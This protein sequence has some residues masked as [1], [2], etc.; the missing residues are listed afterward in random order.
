M[1]E[2]RRGPALPLLLLLL[3][4]GCAAWF[5]GEAPELAA[6]RAQASELRG[7]AFTRRVPL[8]WITRGKLPELVREELADAVRE[9]YATRYRDAAAALGLIPPDLDLVELQIRLNQEQIAG[10]YSVKKRRMYVLVDGPQLD[11]A[12][13]IH[14]LVHALQH[15]HFR[16]TLEL[17]QALRRND[18]VVLALGAAAEGDAMLVMQL[19]RSGDGELGAEGA[20]LQRTWLRH[21]LETPSG[22][23]AE[24]PR[25]VRLGLLFP[26][27]AGFDLA[28]QVY[29][30]EGRA[31]LD[32]LL[33]DAPLSSL[34]VRRPQSRHDVEFLRLPSARAEEL[35]GPGCRAGHDNVAGV[36]ALGALFADHGGAPA[37]APL[38]GSWS[39]DRF[40]RLDCP[41]GPE[42]LWVT[43]W[44]TPEAATDFAAAY[45]AIAPKVARVAPLA[46]IPEVVVRDRT[47]LVATPRLAEEAD[48]LLRGTEVRTYATLGSWVEDGCFPESPCPGGI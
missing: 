23:L 32:H 35:A 13:V 12:I 26:Y 41:Q 21:D 37:S 1:L 25:I 14:E 34:R 44:T 46:G 31:G 36:V 27:A 42:L 40:L 9:G 29:R 8:D 2:R 4:G 19:Y 39:G 22:L 24:V 17:M 48:L 5:S 20:E 18:D 3:A 33:R 45:R 11:D 7:L 28:E 6:W 16:R 10:F 15:Q 47:A 38:E 43:R 30:A